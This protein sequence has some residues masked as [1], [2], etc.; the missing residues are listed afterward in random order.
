[1]ALLSTINFAATTLHHGCFLAI[2]G[3]DVGDCS[4]SPGLHLFTTQLVYF[5]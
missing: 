2:G 4:L 1:M 5:V 3:A